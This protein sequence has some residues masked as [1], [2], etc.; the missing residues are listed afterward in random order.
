MK[1]LMTLLMG[2]VVALAMSAADP[3]R[4]TFTRTGTTADGVAVSVGGAEGASATMTASHSLKALTNAAIVC[5]DA[6]GNTNPEITLTFNVAGLPAGTRFN[7]LG[8]HVWAYN[9]AGGLQAS[10]DS[11]NRQY[12]VNATVNGGDFVSWTNLDPAAGITGVNKLWTETA[13]EAVEADGTLTLTLT[14]TAG[15][16]N[17]GCFFGLEAVELGY[18]D[19]VE[20]EPTPDPDP[21]VPDVPGT[22]VY[23]LQ[24]MTTPSEYMAEDASGAVITSSYSTSNRIFWQFIP[25]ENENCYYIRN[26]ATGNYI[27]SCNLTPASASKIHTGKT[28]VEYYLGATAATTGTIAGGFWLSSTDCA[29]YSNESA[30]P[31]ALNRDGASQTVITWQAGVSRT[32]SYWKLKETADLY[33]A[34][35]FT[36]SAEVGKPAASYHI[37]NPEGLALANDGTWVQKDVKDGTQR[38]YFVGSSNADGGYQI[39]SFADNRAWAD[40]KRYTVSA[41]N[42]G[43]PYHFA[44]AEGNRLIIGGSSDFTITA[45]RSLFALTNQIYQIPCGTLGAV[46]ITQVTIGDGF[47]YPMAVKK[48]TSISYPT[49]TKP[50]NKYVILSR[51]AAVLHPGTEVP[52]EIRLS[53][54]PSSATTLRL[55]VDWDGDGCFEYAKALACDRSVTDVISVPADAAE[56]K[57]RA[58]LRLTDNGLTDA[59]AD[60]R[61]EVLDLLFLV[62][63]S[64][65]ELVEPVVKVNDPA[66]GT[67]VWADGVATATPSGNALLLY[68]LDGVRI[69]SLDAAYEVAASSEERVL[70]AVFS[71]N[72]KK[73]AEGIDPDLLAKVD[74][75]GSISYD[76][77][78]ISVTSPAEAKAILLF[79]TD[80]RHIVTAAGGRLATK[81]VV[82]GVYIVKAVTAAGVVSAKVKI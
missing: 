77:A 61:G 44:D 72:T 42:G 76:G 16:E 64:A 51:D 5:P 80:G 66:R 20:P 18:S 17:V 41:T 68:W 13:A 6:N 78:F 45:A 26:T 3:V 73:V 35:P 33:E 10:D 24:W 46:W 40:G 22:K 15:D 28:P 36:P 21:I 81:G 82:P 57:V 43:A 71:A 25:T 49:A 47:H 2:F 69:V 9:G 58:R 50:A 27:G 34:R 55:Y 38:W 56:G 70:T 52:V 79:G 65:E 67:A 37:V 11:K 54:K 12:N 4:L 63:R 60:V 75:K 59:D 62:T 14:I 30:G 19:G 29:D 23:T 53:A 7:T 48:G 32:G 39:V 31:R 8:V 1:N 74:G